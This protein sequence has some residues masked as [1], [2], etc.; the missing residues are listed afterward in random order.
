MV[1]HP[2][3][4]IWE[5]P[6]RDAAMHTAEQGDFTQVARL[7]DAMRSDGLIRGLLGTRGALLN[8]PVMHE[9]DPWVVERLKGR[10]AEYDPET[11]AILVERVPGVWDRMTPRPELRAVHDDGLMAGV[12]LG[13]LCDDPTPG[14]WRRLK[15][16]DLHWLRYRHSEDSWWY[17][18]TL[19]PVRVT[20]GDGRWTMFTPYGRERPW[21]RG[22]WY[23]CAGPFI[24]KQGAAID[25]MRWQ[26]FLADGLRYI[27]AGEQAS[28]V[29]L[30]E[31][32]RFIRG[33]WQY[34]PGLVAPKGYEPG[35]VEASGRGYEVY[36][37]TEDRGDR[38]IQVALA[39]QVVTTDGGKGF[40]S[41]DIWRDIASNL[42][43]ETADALGVWAGTDIIDPYTC[44]I[45][46]G[47]G[48]VQAHWDARDPSQK[49][50]AAAAA[51]GVAD[52]IDAIDKVAAPRGQRVKLTTFFRS[53]GVEVDL[54][55]IT[56]ETPQPAP[57]L[58]PPGAPAGLL[59]AAPATAAEDI[60]PPADDAAARLAEAMTEH[61][62]DRCEHESLNR[63]RLCG[64]ERERVLVPGVDGA[65]HGW[66]IAW[67]PIKSASP[68]TV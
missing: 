21:A 42:I 45:G 40:S 30:P 9:G 18:T 39:G 17:Q 38:E 19:G 64:V 11:G 7:C 48:R 66:R 65:P 33:G 20:P 15:H 26:R 32:L 46:L 5:L 22:A 25:R 6:D 1:Q 59:P 3:G 28:E 58:P 62:V 31:M 35:I 29:H 12:G 27:K 10:P 52:A 54:E 53:Q 51:K 55:S 57:A 37:D 68:G 34:A 4:H 63:C 14:G 44:V 41:G 36:T 23:P 61:G 67:R 13:Y 49:S 24:G 56:G 50:A 2:A 8:F 43:Q 60:A 16:L 47:S